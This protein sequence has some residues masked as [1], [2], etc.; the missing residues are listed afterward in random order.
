[1]PL[2][3]EPNRKFPVILEVDAGKENP[4][5]F[6]FKYLT[7]RDWRKL[8]EMSDKITSADGGAEAID[9]IYESLGKGLVGW[10]NMIDPETHEPIPFDIKELDRM[11]SMTETHELMEK[12]RNQGIGADDKKK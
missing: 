7:G 9:L 3:L 10:E 6:Y 11:V 4:P 2:G 12:F 8:A 1:M 5:T